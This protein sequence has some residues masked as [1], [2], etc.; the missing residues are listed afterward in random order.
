MIH[1]NVEEAIKETSEYELAEMAK[2]KKLTLT[3][4]FRKDELDIYI[5]T[6][7]NS[8]KTQF[9]Y[10]NNS[11]FDL[12]TLRPI[13]YALCGNMDAYLMECPNGVVEL[14][15]GPVTSGLW[16]AGA[17]RIL[18]YGERILNVVPELGYKYRGVEDKMV[19]RRIEE[20]VFLIERMC[21][22]NSVAYSTALCKAVE[23]NNTPDRAEYI[24]VIA[25]ELERLYN[26]FRVIQRLA[27]AASQ[28]VATSH[29]SALVEEVLRLNA[30]LFKH[31][32][33]FGLNIP[34]GVRRNIDTDILL[35]KLDDIEKEFEELIDLL[36]NSRIFIDRIH[37]TAVLSKDDVL[38][39]DAVGVTAKGSG[40]ERD[41]RTFDSF[42]SETPFSVALQHSGD[43]LARMVVRVEEIRNSIEIIRHLANEMP[44]TA[45]KSD[46]K[47]D[48]FRYGRVEAPQGDVLVV[49]EAKDDI[50][51]WVGI[52]PSS[53]INYVAFAHAVR[54]NIF[55]DFPFAIESFGLSFAEADR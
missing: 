46:N 38:R 30:K 24:R 10:V 42:Y 16:E 22:T 48:G 39:L 2:D 7:Y 32:Y 20:A 36:L 41:V 4:Y 5:W 12:G 6:D 14:H 31:R 53:L 8:G 25:L 52:R 26:H 35:R 33:I 19:G 11:E 51:K 27:M 44:Q 29:F 9:T 13:Y 3:A 28:K 23:G 45:L 54:G 40:V 17:F 1:G 21:G 18:T 47:A 55:T 49:V 43:S 34:G 37:N 50:L 15:Y